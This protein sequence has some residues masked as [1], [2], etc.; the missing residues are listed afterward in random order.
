MAGI[1]YDSWFR[2]MV[3][4]LVVAAGYHAAAFLCPQYV[5]FLCRACDFV[6]YHWR[7]GLFVLI[8]LS[9]VWPMLR[10]P[11]WF[12]PLFAVFTVQQLYS[13]VLRVL[14]FEGQ[15]RFDWISVAVGILM[16]ITLALLIRERAR[17][18]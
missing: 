18:R 9:L 5:A 14:V 8:D 7:N 3:A 17:S 15:G 4:A 13:H 6:G 1:N 16:P 2:F 12:M 10:R 11:R